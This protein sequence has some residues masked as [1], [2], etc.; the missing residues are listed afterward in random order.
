MDSGLVLRTS[1]NDVCYSMIIPR[2]ADRARNV[3]I[4]RGELHASAGGLLA[5]GR[6]IELLPRRLVSR[7][8]EAALR[9]QIGV[10]F[11]QFL[12]RNQDVGVALVEVD[13]NPVA[14][15]QNRK[16]AVG[17]GLRRGVED[18]RRT[19]GAGLPSVADAGQ[20]EDTAFD[21]CR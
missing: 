10:A 6:A 21:Q 9:L 5:D 13:A 7:V 15:A 4:A 11:A 16:S 19:R 8:G 18:R 17:G 14:G 2:H 1:R 3:L 20:R 12:I